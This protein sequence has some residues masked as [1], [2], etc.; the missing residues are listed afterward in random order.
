MKAK[1]VMSA[2]LALSMLTSVCVAGAVSAAEEEAEI[3]WVLPQ[4]MKLGE[5][6]SLLVR[7][8]NL[9]T[10]GYQDENGWWHSDYGVRITPWDDANSELFGLG[11]YCPHAGDWTEVK[12]DGTCAIGNEDTTVVPFAPG[13]FTYQFQVYQFED[14][15]VIAEIGDPYTVTIEEP[16]IQSNAPEY[17]A[18]GSTLDFKTA[19]TNTA[20]ENEEVAPYLDAGNYAIYTDENGNV[21]WYPEDELVHKLAFHPTVEIVEGAE[22]VQSSDQDYTHTLESSE[23]LTFTGTGTVKLKV[24][25]RQ[26]LRCTSIGGYDDIVK[27]TAFDPEM[28][29]EGSYSPEQII[30]IQVTEDGKAP[31]GGTEESTTKPDSDSTAP[32]ETTTESQNGGANTSSPNTGDAGFV[33]PLAMLAVSGGAVALLLRRKKNR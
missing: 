1:K 22:L 11:Q 15:Q 7:G 30:T 19:L 13:S 8:K 14:N 20:L 29:F 24:T 31:S 12:Q 25:Y 16:V 17:A 27:A 9:P 10:K 5:N 32:S 26:I 3:E 6:A 23:K 21:N 2:A 28:D 33:L 18:V 4:T